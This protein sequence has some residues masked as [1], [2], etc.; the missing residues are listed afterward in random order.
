MGVLNMPENPNNVLVSISGQSIGKCI[1]GPTSAAD[2]RQVVHKHEAV[3]K[4]DFD[5]ML[6]RWRALVPTAVWMVD[7]WLQ[8]V[9]A[10]EGLFSSVAALSCAKCGRHTREDDESKPVLMWGPRRCYCARTCQTSAWP[11]EN[12]YL[13]EEFQS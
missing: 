9:F 11:Q 5:L 1:H 6:A 12:S 2:F 7:E 4:G 10:R 13:Q 3:D 8:E